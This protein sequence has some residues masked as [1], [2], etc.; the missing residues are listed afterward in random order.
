MGQLL[1]RIVSYP[2][3]WHFRQCQT[4]V[5]VEFSLT[6]DDFRQ[7]EAPNALMEIHIAKD[8]VLA[9]PVFFRLKP[10]TVLEAER[11][12]I[13]NFTRPADDNVS[14]SIAGKV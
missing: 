3:Y 5:G 9:N 7:N 12:G 4:I 10:M 11:S 13:L 2:Y 8:G 14:P 1:I 6:N